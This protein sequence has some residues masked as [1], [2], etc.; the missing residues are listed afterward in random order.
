MQVLQIEFLDITLNKDRK[1]ICVIKIFEG[2]IYQY[3]NYILHMFSIQNA[4][5]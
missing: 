2:Y 5:Q 1:Y 4:N 3:F